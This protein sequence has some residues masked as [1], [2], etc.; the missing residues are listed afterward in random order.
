MKIK[1]TIFSLFLVFAVQQASAAD[2]WVTSAVGGVGLND[3]SSAVNAC[4]LSQVLLDNL[5]VGKPVNPGDT[6]IIITGAHSFG[7]LVISQEFIT[8]KGQTALAVQTVCN[9]AT[10]TCLTATGAYLSYDGDPICI[11]RASRC[12]IFEDGNTRCAGA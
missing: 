10:D 3:C 5:V 8:I 4:E 1:A 2:V 11:G 12:R 6:V 9:P 7:P